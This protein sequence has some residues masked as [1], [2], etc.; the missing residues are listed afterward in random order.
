M[1]TW[2]PVLLSYAACWQFS[3][4][5]LGGAP[6]WWQ[7]HSG[8][9]SLQ[10]N[11]S[12]NS[13]QIVEHNEDTVQFGLLV[14]CMYFITQ[15]SIL[16]TL[17]S[18]QLLLLYPTPGLLW[19]VIN[20]F[21][22]KGDH[23]LYLQRLNPNI[24]QRYRLEREDPGLSPLSFSASYRDKHICLLYLCKPES[25]VKIFLCWTRQARFVTDWW[26]PVTLKKTIIMCFLWSMR[27]HHGCHAR[28]VR[29]VKQRVYSWH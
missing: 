13:W 19:L 7:S 12:Q 24:L 2:Y 10:L 25:A 22:Q 4:L 9:S 16:N 6:A 5:S 26:N 3:F 18:H 29:D 20:V 23:F 1:L 14:N 11:R 17:S 27:T 15:L 8:S 28:R 21:P